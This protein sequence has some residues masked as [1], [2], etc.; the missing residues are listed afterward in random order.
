MT[1]PIISI[2]L[3]LGALCSG[4][5]L[6][7]LSAKRLTLPPG[8]QALPLI[9]NL[10]TLGNLP[11]QTLCHL[12]K[13]FG[14]IMS[15][16]LGQVLTIVVSSPQA[17][18]LF[19]KTH[20]LVFASRPKLQAANS[21]SYGRKNVAFA[22]YGP[23][24]R[25]IK[26]LCTIELLSTLKIE[27]FAMVRREEVGSLVQSL[28][29]AAEAEMVVNLS[30]KVMALVED[31]SYRM[32]FGRRLEECSELNHAVEEAS[33]LLGTFNLGD[34]L[35]LF[36][37][38]DLQ[39][40]N[41]RTKAARNVMDKILE[42][43][44]DEHATNASKNQEKQHTDFTDVMLSIMNETVLDNNNTSHGEDQSRHFDRDNI[45]AIAFEM[46]IGG[47][48]T[49]TTAIEWTLSELIKNP[50]VMTK[51]QQELENVIGLGKMV[52]ESDLTRCDYL[53]MVIKESFRLHPVGP[54]LIP[55]ESVEDITINGHF[56]PKKSRVMINTW[57]IGRDEDTWYTKVHEFFPERFA[58][59]TID[60]RGRHFEL[61]P[62]G[63]GRRMCPGIHMA[64][65]TINLVV[66]QLV[67][68]FHWELPD[69]VLATN[70][71]MTEKFGLSVRRAT[72]LYA[73]P[74]FR[75]STC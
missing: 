58:N 13:Q 11:H 70:L 38:L 27:S 49:T 68:C 43:I 45:K 41:R 71:D 35:P 31:I 51:L 4:V 67:H 52:H 23:Y 50:K 60:V 28:K 66:A 19:L 44:I 48:E 26:K 57:A 62:F 47:S 34:V 61:L 7:R 53:D 18:E 56:I 55:R 64:M 14:S 25:E 72:E 65:V 73:R 15:I 5:Y 20:D 74:T 46:L 54:F 30:T 59:S 33:T 17:A 16:R 24:W 32:L 69:G 22:D 39:G 29:V 75:L 42:Q 10:H 12:S 21:L 6:R 1:L 37:L 2:L 9:G 40:I 3:L 36:G 63:S 8:P